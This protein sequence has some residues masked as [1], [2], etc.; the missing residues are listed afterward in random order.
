MTRRHPMRRLPTWGPLLAGLV[1]LAAWPA[2]APADQPVQYTT[3][4]ELH[5]AAGEG[6][7]R[8]V[9]PL[10]V[11]RALQRT[12]G[13]DLR[14]FNGR[15]EPVPQAW[16]GMPQA[17]TAPPTLHELPRFAWPEPARERG[18]DL[19]VDIELGRDG[20]W[21]FAS[22]AWSADG[23][24]ARRV[25]DRGQALAVELYRHAGIRSVE[26]GS[27]MFGRHDPATGEETYAQNELV[28]LAI[29]RRVYTQSH[30]DY[31]VEALGEIA[32]HRHEIPGVR[33]VE[34]PPALRHFSA[35]FAPVT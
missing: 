2:D 1:P 29:P 25:S 17:E 20:R 11:L 33:I 19:D 30:V 4:A 24:S 35:A 26:I 5:L 14:V 22:Y 15:G 31:V 34:Q 21:R 18:D 16:A 8:V 32:A 9:L 10:D 27:V 3:R 12:D 23:R 6:L 7:Q 13:E 28:R